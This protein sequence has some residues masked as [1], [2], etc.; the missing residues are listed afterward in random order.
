MNRAATPKQLQDLAAQ[1]RA[2]ETAGD[3]IE[4]FRVLRSA[5]TWRDAQ[6]VMLEAGH[7]VGF[8]DARE[9]WRDA[10]AH[11]TQACRSG[12]DGFGLRALRNPD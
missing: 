1:L 8:N 10:Q 12:V 7:T 4:A 9:F 6:T 3:Q 5:P 2:A 11:I